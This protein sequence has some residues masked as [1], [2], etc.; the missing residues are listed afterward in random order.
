V[1]YFHSR[2]FDKELVTKLRQEIYAGYGFRLILE[3]GDATRYEIYMVMVPRAR[4]TK[5]PQQILVTAFPG[6]ES[7]G[8][9]S[10]TLVPGVWPSPDYVAEKMNFR[11]YSA[12]LLSVIMDAVVNEADFDDIVGYARG[13]NV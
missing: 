11:D 4:D 2:T 13:D 12:R 8:F 1:K 10:M 5:E 9:T 6:S 3:P 7:G